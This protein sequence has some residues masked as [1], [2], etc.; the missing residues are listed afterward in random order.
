M[1]HEYLHGTLCGPL[2]RGYS[3]YAI[4]VEHGFEG[5]EEEWIASLK[6][7]TPTIVRVTPGII[8]IPCDSNGLCKDSY[9]QRVTFEAVRG[10]E[11]INCRCLE[12]KTEESPSQ[13]YGIQMFSHSQC[14][15]SQEGRFYFRFTAGTDPF[16]GA[17][18]DFD[19]LSMPAYF[20][21]DDTDILYR[22]I[23]VKVRDAAR[24]ITDRVTS[25][26]NTV[27]GKGNVIE[28]LGNPVYV[29]EAALSQYSSYG[30]TDT[31]WYVFA[32][33]TPPEGVTIGQETAVSCE[34]SR[35]KAV[36]GTDH[37]DVAVIFDVASVS[38][39]IEITWETGNS[40][41]FVFKSTDLA[42]RNLDYRVTFY[43][44][45]ADPFATW[46]YAQTTDTT[47]AA[48]KRYYTKDGDTYTFAEVTA[49]QDVP[50]D[51][52]YYVRTKVTIAGLVR[53]VTYR[54]NEIVDC[55]M[56][57]ILPEIEDDCHGAWF[58]I[59]CRHN[60]EYS[61]TLVPPSNDVKIATEH[62]QKETAGVNMINL[63]YTVVDGV[64]VWRF[65]NTHSS[66]PA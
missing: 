7:G 11:R 13:Y 15:P 44:Y 31:G 22:F 39:A 24:P 10:E 3:A 8:P 54:L 37:I 19:S 30:I 35:V 52:T 17:S 56:E 59:R 2:V 61:M 6:G 47:F 29:G 55:P 33:I 1:T 57:F 63:H 20:H 14:T 36:I 26:D 32:R 21:L 53:N 45:D 64:K 28:A 38:R 66:I 65:M 49:G 46:T 48:D 58:E 25:L 4:A 18:S 41:T 60:G 51:I 16:E 34:D 12:G 40:E 5:T 27:F 42:V 50:A 23:F 62:T 43:V 9:D